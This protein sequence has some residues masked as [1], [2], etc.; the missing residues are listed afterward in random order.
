ML[1]ETGKIVAA[2]RKAG[3]GV[4]QIPEAKL[5]DQVIRN[6]LDS[7]VIRPAAGEALVG[8]REEIG[9]LTQHRSKRAFAFFHG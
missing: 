7:S 2:K 3:P 1:F 5:I 4:L 9:R 6:D 8:S